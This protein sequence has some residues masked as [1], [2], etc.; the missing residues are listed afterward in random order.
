MASWI[1]NNVAGR[2]RVARDEHK[3]MWKVLFDPRETLAAEMEHRWLSL[4]E[5]R[6]VGTLKPSNAAVVQ[7][8]YQD[9]IKG[10]AIIYPGRSRRATHPA[11]LNPFERVYRQ[12]YLLE[13]QLRGLALRTAIVNKTSAG[14]K[15]PHSAL[16]TIVKALIS[17]GS[18][19]DV[20]GTF[21]ELY[22][23]KCDSAS[24]GAANRWY[25]AAIV[26]SVPAW[27]FTALHG[28]TLRVA[29]VSGLSRKSKRLD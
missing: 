6:V 17:P 19:D 26:K 9:K 5:K 21:E 22:R 23:L 18:R 29:R 3:G 13:R 10:E 25:A 8:F 7:R 2:N 1:E 28:L 20:L 16:S 4:W 12:L 14:N 15:K 27:I 24:P 11:Q